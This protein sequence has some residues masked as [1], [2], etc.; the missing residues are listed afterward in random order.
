VGVHVRH[1]LEGLAEEAVDLLRPAAH[2]RLSRRQNLLI[3]C[4]KLTALRSIDNPLRVQP[5]GGDP[6]DRI[7][8]EVDEILDV[9]PGLPSDLVGE[10][11]ADAVDGAQDLIG[12]A[13]AFVPVVLEQFALGLVE[14]AVLLLDAE[15]LA[16][17]VE[18]HEVDLAVQGPPLVLAGPV[19]AVEDRVVAGQGVA[20]DREGRYLGLMGTA[21]GQPGEIRGNNSRHVP[22]GRCSH[23]HMSRPGV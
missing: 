2:F 5:G 18:H 15:H 1:H 16:R 6:L 21:Q 22:T 4:C 8:R 17:I 19:H 13:F 9:D 10:L 23:G 3:T 14:S 7:V 20:Q 11:V 12:H